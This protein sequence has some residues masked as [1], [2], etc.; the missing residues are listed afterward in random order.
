MAYEVWD[1][2]AGNLLA[3]F[4]TERDA[5]AAVRTYVQ[6][7]GLQHGEALAVV[8]EGPAGDSELLAEGRELVERSLRSDQAPASQ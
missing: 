6:A 3:T 7:V 2:A 1:T 5:L 4:T 8:L